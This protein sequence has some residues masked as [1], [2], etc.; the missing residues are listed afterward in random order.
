M[1]Y[2]L[3]TH[4]LLWYLKKEGS[5]PAIVQALIQD[6]RNEIIVNIASFWKMAIKNS[7]GKLSLDQPLSILFSETRKQKFQIAQIDEAFIL[8]VNSLPLHHKDPFDRIL[9]AHCLHENIPVLGIDTAFDA[10]GITRIW[11]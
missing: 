5:I 8:I 6:P 4:T 3:D 1:K 10:Y 11:G 9:I 7:I 2:L